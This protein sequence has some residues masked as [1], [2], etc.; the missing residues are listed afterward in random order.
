MKNRI[1]AALAVVIISFGLVGCKTTDGR[2]VSASE[3]LGIAFNKIADFMDKLNAG[4]T[5]SLGQVPVV[6]AWTAQQD[7]KFQQARLD[8]DIPGDIVIAEAKAMAALWGNPN[9]PCNKYP[10]TLAEA[11]RSFQPAYK[12]FRDA[13]ASAVAYANS[14]SK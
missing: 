4:V 2:D 7:M 3:W 9:T 8:Y 13:Q 11:L 10:T 5:Y 14:V 6:C 1:F 12:A